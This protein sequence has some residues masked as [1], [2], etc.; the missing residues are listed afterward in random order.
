MYD[1]KLDPIQIVVFNLIRILL[2]TWNDYKAS[3][4]FDSN[5]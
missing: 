1:T 5:V 3:F 4:S 2:F